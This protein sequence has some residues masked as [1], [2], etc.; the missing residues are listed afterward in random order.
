[1]RPLGGR[2]WH[3]PSSPLPA[4]Q[5]LGTS[6]ASASGDSTEATVS[7]VPAL[8]GWG[9]PGRVAANIARLPELFGQKKLWLDASRKLLVQSE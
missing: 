3:G 7:P 9:G 8:R 4:W 6:R 5:D 1:M 2:M